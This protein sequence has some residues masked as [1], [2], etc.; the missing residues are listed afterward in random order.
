MKLIDVRDAFRRVGVRRFLEILSFPRYDV[1]KPAAVREQPTTSLRR[2]DYLQR[3]RDPLLPQ[4]ETLGE[5]PSPSFVSL[6]LLRSITTTTTAAGFE[7]K[8]LYD[9]YTGQRSTYRTTFA[10]STRFDFETQVRRL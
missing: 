10:S 1:D 4:L 3:E 7:P 9:G 8:S 6:H 2:N 5:H